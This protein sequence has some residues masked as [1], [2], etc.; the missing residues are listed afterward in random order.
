MSDL[1]PHVNWNKKFAFVIDFDTTQGFAPTH[2]FDTLEAAIEKFREFPPGV[3]LR[4]RG[5]KENVIYADSLGTE[6]QFYL[7]PRKLARQP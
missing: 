6:R 3:P 7:P 5:T 2:G 1:P 4:V